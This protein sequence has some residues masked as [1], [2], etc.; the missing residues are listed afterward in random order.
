[1]NRIL[2]LLLFFTLVSCSTQNAPPTED[3]EVEFIKGRGIQGKK[4][5]IY[6]ITVPHAWIRRDPL[7]EDTIEDTTQALCEF[8]IND[9]EGI[10]RIAIHNFPSDTLEARIPPAAQVARWK[11]QLNHYKPEEIVE[12]PIAFGGYSGV[13]FVG[14][15]KKEDKEFRV[16]ATALQLAPEHFKN[17]ITLESSPQAVRYRQMRGDVTLKAQGPLVAMEKQRAAIL[18]AYH[19]FGLIDEIPQRR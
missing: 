2:T 14:T 13:Q 8:I 9:P 12:T 7:P 6:R 10:I 3:T 15:S 19:S 17:L 11:Q 1:M 5:A 4:L 16:F 18:Q